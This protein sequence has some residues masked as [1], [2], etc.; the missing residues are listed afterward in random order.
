MAAAG[1]LLGL[2]LTL[3]PL[4]TTPAP[5]PSEDR[6]QEEKITES[7]RADTAGPTSAQIGP[8]SLTKQEQESSSNMFV[9]IAFLALPA[10]VFSLLAYRWQLRRM[11]RFNKTDRVKFALDRHQL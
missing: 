3:L 11:R 8:S 10:S 4:S 6:T 7:A 5:T 2:T 1:I 9:A